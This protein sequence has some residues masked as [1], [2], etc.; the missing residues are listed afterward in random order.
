MNFECTSSFTLN[1]KTISRG[2][3]ISES[4]YRK[5]SS[6][7]QSN[8]RRETSSGYA[9]N[10]VDDLIDGMILGSIVS[11]LFD[12]DSSSGFGSSD[13]SNSSFDFGG[14]EFGGGGAGGDW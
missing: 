14:G 6:S 3:I 11:S 8:F 10:R 12:S 2:T 4:A 1:G 9:A 5:L 13:S 7:N